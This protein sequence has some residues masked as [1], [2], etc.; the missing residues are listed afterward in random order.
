MIRFDALHDMLDRI[1]TLSHD[2]AWI[3]AIDKNVREDIIFMNTEDQLWALGV[4]SKGN[5][6]TPAY[7]PFTVG[8]K[9]QRGQRT[10]H[11]TLKDTGAF[12]NSF[13]VTVQKDSFTINADTTTDDGDDL[14]VKYGIDIIGL[15][16]KNLETMNIFIKENYI[17]YVHARLL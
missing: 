12:Y 11:V 5:T 15:T 2:E 10:D 4:D 14:A 9:R 13:M 1:G 3:F 7:T 16:D 8:L 17:D 6:L